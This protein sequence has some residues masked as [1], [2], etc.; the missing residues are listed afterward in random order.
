MVAETEE[1]LD[2]GSSRRARVD[3]IVPNG[4]KVVNGAHGPRAGS[5]F[6]F[7]TMRESA[8]KESF[9]KSTR[10]GKYGCKYVFN[11]AAKKCERS[12]FAKGMLQLV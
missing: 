9:E 3:R 6:P 8:R 2:R 7:L 1:V 5:V 4:G 12:S 11:F 10:H